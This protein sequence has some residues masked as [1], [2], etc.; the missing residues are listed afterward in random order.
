MTPSSASRSSFVLH[1]AVIEHLPQ[2]PAALRGAEGVGIIQPSGARVAVVRADVLEERGDVAHR[3][4]AEPN[5]PTTARRV[6]QLV[7]APRLETGVQVHVIRRRVVVRLHEGP[8]GAR[9]F[10]GRRVGVVAHL[11]QGPG[12]VDV[13][14]RVRRVFA[15]G[16]HEHRGRFVDLKL[17]QDAPLQRTLRSQRFRCLQAHQAR[18][19]RHVR[20]PTAPH[21]G[22]APAHEEAVSRLGRQGVIDDVRRVVETLHNRFAPAIHHVEEHPAVAALGVG[23]L[24]HGEL[25]RERHRAVRLARRQVQVGDGGVA[26]VQ[27]VYR[28]VRRALQE[29]VR[30]CRVERLAGGER[31]AL[32][33]VELDD[34]H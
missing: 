31:R 30:P 5:D 9:N 13:G 33:D 7:D 15:V 17:T 3:G 16:E 18:R 14:G 28:E 23:G 24:Q 25:R 2:E 34:C 8:R 32:C 27:R 21:H 20:L 4:K 29:F 1:Q 26:R 12:L 10:D 22:I 6:H 19:R 11:Q